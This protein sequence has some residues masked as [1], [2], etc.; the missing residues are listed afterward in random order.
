MGS[1]SFSRLITFIFDH[2]PKI[3]DCIWFQ[4]YEKINAAFRL[5]T[6]KPSFDVV[7]K[8]NKKKTNSY[9]VQNRF[10]QDIDYL[11][12]LGCFCICH[13]PS[14]CVMLMKLNK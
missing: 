6:L 7:Y 2:K 5:F 10:N 12:P 8:C 13:W 1:S 3:S 9:E 11:P 4:V 14:F